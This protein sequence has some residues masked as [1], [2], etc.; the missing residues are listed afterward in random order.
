MDVTNSLSTWC[1]MVDGMAG[2]ALA[3][4]A[5]AWMQCW[6]RLCAAQRCSPMPWAAAA[7]STAA[8]V[9]GMALCSCY[10]DRVC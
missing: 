4:L 9:V 1:S 2:V 8:L 6:K 7:S 5:C 10:R 3:E